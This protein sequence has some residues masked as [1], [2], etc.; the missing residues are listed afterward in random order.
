MR[1]VYRR[2]IDW[3]CHRQSAKY[4]YSDGIPEL[5]DLPVLNNSPLESLH[6]KTDQSECRKDNDSLD[7]VFFPF[8]MLWLCGPTE[9]CHNIFR[10][11]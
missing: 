2:F 7:P 3:K 4:H 9:E 1:L 6:I 5:T 8:I 11:L 10:H